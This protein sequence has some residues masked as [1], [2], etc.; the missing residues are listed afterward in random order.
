MM[1]EREVLHNSINLFI[2]IYGFLSPYNLSSST[3]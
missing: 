2:H 1:T 3:Q